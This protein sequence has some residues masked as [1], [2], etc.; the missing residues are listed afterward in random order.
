MI[1]GRGPS[2]GYHQGELAA[3]SRAGFR[4]Q[5]QRLLPVIGGTLP[6]GVGGFLAAQQILFVGAADPEGRVWASALHGDR[7]FVRARDLTTLDIASSPTAV[8]PLAGTLSGHARVGTLA[9]DFPHRRRLRVNGRTSP[10]DHGLLLDVDQAYGNCPQYI[11][12][13][14]PQQDHGGAPSTRLLSTGDGLDDAQRRLV[15]NADTFFIASVSAAGDA[16]VSHRGGNPGFVH[17]ESPTRLSW[18]DY[19]GNTMLMTLGNL[20]ATPEA[21]LLFVDWPSGTT[22][23]LTGT[24]AI[25][26]DPAAAARV[27]GAQRIVVFDIARTVVIEHADAPAWS[28]P[29]FSRFNPPVA[30]NDT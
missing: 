5:A 25:D 11:Q 19:A 8:D 6:R 18:P 15:A 29:E 14:T 7:G 22:M 21:G 16:D 13:R 1:D 30:E 9:I 28:A 20:T 26:W 24:A 10:A 23:H 4:A 27:P 3:Q 17:V 12:S 2:T